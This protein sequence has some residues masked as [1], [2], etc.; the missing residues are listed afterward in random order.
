LSNVQFKLKEFNEAK[1]GY[2]LAL[3]IFKKLNRE[4]SSEYI[5]ILSNLILLY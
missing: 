1:N 5:S 2:L 3:K 4:Y